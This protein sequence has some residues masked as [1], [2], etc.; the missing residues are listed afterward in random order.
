MIEKIKTWIRQILLSNATPTEVSEALALGVFIGFT[1]TVGFHTWMALG[2][3]VLF[4]KNKL[5]TIVGAYITNPITLIPIFYACFRLG[6]WIMGYDEP[7]GFSKTLFLHPFSLGAKILIPLWVGSLIVGLVSSIATYYL[8]LFLYKR[9]A[10][11]IA[12]YRK[13]HDDAQRRS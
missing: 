10:A 7:V 11:R 5:V 13:A 9:F 3:A 4:K 1:P 2:L 8:T 12:A 6:E